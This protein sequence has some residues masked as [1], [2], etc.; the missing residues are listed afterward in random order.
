MNILEIIRGSVRPVLTWMFGLAFCIAFFMG[1]IPS[2]AFCSVAT[3]V[4]VWWF[5]D[6]A[7]SSAK[8]S[9]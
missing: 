7:I 5:K 4:V 3:G 6:K 8:G 1:K 9:K 2:E